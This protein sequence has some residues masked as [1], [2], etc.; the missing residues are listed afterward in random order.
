MSVNQNEIIKF[1]LTQVKLHWSRVLAKN[2]ILINQNSEVIDLKSINLIACKASQ[3]VSLSICSLSFENIMSIITDFSTKSNLHIFIWY[4][5]TNVV[6]RWHTSTLSYPQTW[7]WCRVVDLLRITN[8]NNHG[9]VWVAKLF[10]SVQL[11]N[12]MSHESYGSV[13]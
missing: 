11:P 5:V 10:H 9:R 3:Q 7:M 13:V 8:S 4:R 6:Y 12:P 2:R 1:C